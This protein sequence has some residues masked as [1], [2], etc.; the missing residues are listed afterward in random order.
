[1][2]A[3]VDRPVESLCNGGRLLLWAMRG[4]ALAIERGCCPA[5]A[6]H[7]G[8]AGVGA[9]AALPDVHVAFALLVSGSR[10]RLAFAPMGC[11]RIG[12]VEAVL[13]R[14]WSDAASGGT[15]TAR[16]TLGLLIDEASVAPAHAAI[17]AAASQ[18]AAAGFDLSHLTTPSPSLSGPS[19]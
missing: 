17:D 18:L 12:E 1:M 10:T 14:L 15:D 13:L 4:W 2:Y 6:L 16:A 11:A 19:T 3:L 8:F 7:R 9:L 5:R